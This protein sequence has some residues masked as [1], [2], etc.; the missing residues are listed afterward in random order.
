M[1]SAVATRHVA[2]QQLAVAGVLLHA[3]AVAQLVATR[4]RLRLMLTL[5]ATV[6]WSPCDTARAHAVTCSGQ[7]IDDNPELMCWINMLTFCQY[8]GQ[9]REY[10]HT[11]TPPMTFCSQGQHVPIVVSVKLRHRLGRQSLQRPHVDSAQSRG[12]V[13]SQLCVWLG[14]ASRQL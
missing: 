12:H 11:N 9:S 4:L 7:D 14:A 1:F 6:L 10:A 13:T 3:P 8:Q 5:L 2:V